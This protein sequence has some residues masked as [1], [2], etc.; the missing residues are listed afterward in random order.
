MAGK[1]FGPMDEKAPR[2]GLITGVLRR[3]PAPVVTRPAESKGDEARFVIVLPGVRED[4]FSVAAIP[5]R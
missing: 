5:F 4:L 3:P 1:V 2:F